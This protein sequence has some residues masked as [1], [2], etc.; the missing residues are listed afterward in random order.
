MKGLGAVALL[1]IAIA[2]ILHF[3][4]DEER[5][6]LS[7]PKGAIRNSP[8]AT[9]TD[10]TPAQPVVSTPPPERTAPAGVAER[11][12][13]AP[14]HITIGAPHSVRAGETFPATI[15]VQA[16]KGVRQLVFSVV[17]KKAILELVGTS[18]GAF[19]RQGGPSVQF[20]EVSEGSVLVRV[21][22]E[23]GVLAGA[24]SVAVVEFQARTRG[25]SPLAIHDVTYVAEGRQTESI[26][27][28]AFEGTINVE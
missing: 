16:V 15:D 1:V 7:A 8:V 22:L 3:W 4:S 28:V 24:G 13:I 6:P 12:A 21:G 26:V 27:P 18:P 25:V 23:G 17:Y 20:E 14:L 10:A 5:P 2:A 19:S 9:A 11:P